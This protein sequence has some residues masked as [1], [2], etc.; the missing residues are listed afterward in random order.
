MRGDGSVAAGCPVGDAGS[1][2]LVLAGK[3]AAVL[4]GK[5]VSSFI[6]NVILLFAGK[7]APIGILSLYLKDTG[8]RK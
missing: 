5:L 4:A 8:H 3:T 7:F 1:F 2:G 6:R